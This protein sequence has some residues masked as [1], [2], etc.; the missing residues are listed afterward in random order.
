[1]T[2]T[3]T[4]LQASLSPI[5]V[6]VAHAMVAAE[7]DHATTKGSKKRTLESI[8]EEH[9][10]HRSTISR[11]KKNPDFTAYMAAISRQEIDGMRPIAYAQLMRLVVGTSQ[12]SIPS[13]KALELFFKISGDLTTKTETTT[14]VID[15]G[16]LSEKQ[17]QDGLRRM[18]EE[19]ENAVAGLDDVAKPK[20]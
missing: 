1:M 14:T 7:F 16:K 5:Q 15:G 9:G 6:D 19:M 12:N 17:L 2:K 3:I 4:E 10:I 11:Y 8:A 13:I 20:Q 18:S